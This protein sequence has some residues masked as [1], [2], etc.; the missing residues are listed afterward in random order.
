[1]RNDPVSPSQ[2][3]DVMKHIRTAQSLIENQ[4]I[5]VACFS[6]AKRRGPEARRGSSFCSRLESFDGTKLAS[7]RAPRSDPPALSP[8]S[9]LALPTLL[10]FGVVP[11]CFRIAGICRLDSRWSYHRSGCNRS[12]P[13]R[14]NIARYDTPGQ[15]KSSCCIPPP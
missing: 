9:H 14:H 3:S 1:M 7:Y 6:G 4:S 15:S 5:V 12:S 2:A 10:P 8:L 11:Q 13:D